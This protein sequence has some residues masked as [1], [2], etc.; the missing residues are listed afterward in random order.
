MVKVRLQP[1]TFLWIEDL[2]ELIET[3]SSSP[4]YPPLKRE[5]E[6]FVSETAYD[7]VKFVEDV[8]RD[9]VLSL[10]ERTEVLWFDIECTNFESIHNHNAYARHSE[11]KGILKP[12]APTR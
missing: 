2:I 6:R 11:N 3:Q 12:L 4:I 10:R 1:G 7:N 5:D 8:V 9:L